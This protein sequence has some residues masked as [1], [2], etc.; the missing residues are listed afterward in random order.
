MT[1]F[2]MSK[3]KIVVVFLVLIC[4]KTNIVASQSW[5]SDKLLKSWLINTFKFH[6]L[7]ANLFLLKRLNPFASSVS[8]S[9]QLSNK[10][11]EAC[12]HIKLKKISQNYRC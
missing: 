12:F 4:I 7:E 10:K 9:E 8:Q 2:K 6:T 3:K 11:I 5:L 1:K